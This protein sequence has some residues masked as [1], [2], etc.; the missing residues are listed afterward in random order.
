MEEPSAKP[1]VADKKARRRSKLVIDGIEIQRPAM[2]PVTPLWR[3]RRAAKIAYKKLA[4]DLA[5]ET[6]IIARVRDRLNAGNQGARPLPG[7][8][9]V[10][11]DYAKHLRAAPGIIVAEGLDPFHRL[12]H[13]DFLWT[14]YT[15]LAADGREAI[16]PR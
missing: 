5:A 12:S 13:A 16:Q 11:D 15:A 2:P 14:I 6:E 8:N 9:S 3:L 1:A 4:D 7:A 10:Q